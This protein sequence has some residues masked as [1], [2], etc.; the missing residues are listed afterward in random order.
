MQIE[1]LLSEGRSDYAMVDARQR[2]LHE[3]V[4]AGT[5]PDTLMLI[6]FEPVYTAGSRTKSEDIP[7][8]SVPVV[9]IDRGGSV[10]YHGPGQL[11]VY[12]IINVHGRQDVVAYV[13]ALEQSVINLL[14]EYGIESDRIDGRT[15]VW[16]QRPGE[17]D[18]KICAI[19]VRFS[20]RTTMHGLALNVTTNLDGFGRIVP[21]GIR[22]AGVVSMRDLG[23]EQTLEEVAARLIPHLETQLARF[24]APTKDIA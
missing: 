12:P 6:E 10:T 11:V 15:G 1:N 8:A 13:R 22:D 17:F 2:D 23:I 14:A 24:R 16:I 20:R 7:D 19:G 5:A 21:C 4:A 18:R 9:Q 3:C